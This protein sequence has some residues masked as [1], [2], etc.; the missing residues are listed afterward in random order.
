MVRERLTL[1][2][3]EG[4]SSGSEYKQ[5]I[6][7]TRHFIYYILFYHQSFVFYKHRLMTA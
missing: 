4:G 1:H 7:D 3:L 5:R 6:S 2:L